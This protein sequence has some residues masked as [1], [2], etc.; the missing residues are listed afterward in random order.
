[1]AYMERYAEIRRDPRLLL[2]GAKS[3][4]VC[5]FNYYPQQI[6]DKSL[7]YIS[8]Y[9]YGDDY[10]DVLRRRL[11]PLADTI[12]RLTGGECRICIDTAPLYERYWA[13]QAGIGFTGR[14]S[15]LIV[16]GTGS[17]VFIAS[18]ITTADL[19]PDTPCTLQ[20][21]DGCRRCIDACPGNAITDAGHVNAN[22]CI[23]YLTIEHRG[24]FSEGTDTANC[25]YGCDMCQRVCP[26]NRCVVPTEIAEFAPSEAIMRLDAY[27]VGHMSDS[28]F[29]YTFSHSAIK[30][31]KKEGLRRNAAQLYRKD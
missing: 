11:R 12:T 20:C 13:V 18:V 2:D 26:L 21:P 1:M 27:T 14:H 28:E 17:Y 10:H 9:A 29:S 5:A 8:F 25:L 7:P 6:R 19:K 23:S 16:P 15:Q 31:A 3:I 22:R 30:R 24:P 4:V